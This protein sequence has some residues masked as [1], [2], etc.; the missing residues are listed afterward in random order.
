MSYPSL[1]GILS[2]R[3][4]PLKA[5]RVFAV[6]AHYQSFKQAAEHLF[7]TQA[8]VSQQIRLLEEHLG[9][10]LFI[11]LNREVRL[12]PAGQTLYPFVISGFEELS[13]GLE[14]LNEDSN[15]DALI[16]NCLPSFA[17]R[18]LVPGLGSFQQQN[19]ALTVSII[20]GHAL[21]T[22]EH[23]D[24]DLAIRFGRG[25]YPG[26]KTELLLEDYYLPVCSPSILD[27]YDL[28]K[29]GLGGIPILSDDLPDDDNLWPDFARR[30][31]LPEP[32]HSSLLV[33]DAT[34]LTDAVL[35]GQGLALLRFSL[36]YRLIESEQLVCPLPFYWHSVFSYFLVAPEHHFRRSKV[37]KFRQWIAEEILEISASWK[38]VSDT[39]LSGFEANSLPDSD[40]E[41]P[42][43]QQACG[44]YSTSGKC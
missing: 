5:L 11:R 36:A 30:V 43:I 24:T 28:S 4:P 12:T 10:T 41:P 27:R 40:S 22:F 26:L 42:V 2:G 35:A 1:P 9:Q 14:R 33:H 19:P 32:I 20:P 17:G 37:Q 34:M 31:G 23:S 8:A 39:L 21:E 15:P 16:I 7:V 25:H 38:K 18:W 13:R 3:M 44:P 6:A 29:P